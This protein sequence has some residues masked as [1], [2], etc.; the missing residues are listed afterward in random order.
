MKEIKSRQF[1]QKC[2]ADFKVRFLDSW[3]NSIKTLSYMENV[4][5]ED[6]ISIEFLSLGDLTTMKDEFW[7]GIDILMGR[8]FEKKN[9]YYLF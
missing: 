8:L 5:L 4:K 2:I 9:P 7:Q 3:N 6:I 1:M